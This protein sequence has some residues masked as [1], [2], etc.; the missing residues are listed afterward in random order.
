MLKKKQWKKFQ[1]F[2]KSHEL[3]HWENRIW[4][5]SKADLEQRVFRYL[6]FFFQKE[7]MK[8]SFHFCSKSSWAF[9]LVSSKL[10]Q[11][12]FKFKKKGQKETFWGDSICLEGKMSR[13]PFKVFD[14]DLVEKLFREWEKT[15]SKTVCL[16]FFK[17]H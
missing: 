6:F 1:S 17:Q 13:F 10:F 2:T 9:L 8:K 3:T 15:I 14:I 7:T 16:I 4:G 12:C 5:L 11:H